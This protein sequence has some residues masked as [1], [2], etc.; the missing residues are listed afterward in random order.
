VD[1]SFTREA[2]LNKLKGLKPNKSPGPDRHHPYVLKELAEELAEPLSI[3]F[4]KSMSEG[5]LPQ[6]WKDASVTPIFKKGK[7]SALGNYRPVS[8]TS[9]VCKVIESLVR[10][11]MVAHMTKNV[12]FS[13]FQHGFISGRSCVTN[14]LAVLDAWTEAMDNGTAVDAVYL[15][16]AKAF[17]TVP[18]ERLLIKLQGY[19]IQDK[20]LGWIQ[21]F[22][23]G[24]RQSV[25]VNGAKS[26][27][28]PVTSGVPQGSVIGPVLFVIFINDLPEVTQSIAQMF[29]DDTKVFRSMVTDDDRELLQEDIDQLAKWGNIWQLRFNADKCKVLHIGRNNPNNQY[30]MPTAD[31]RIELET[32]VLEKD[33]G[34]NVDPELKFS[35]HIERQVNK[36]DKILGMI[37]RSYEFIDRDTMKRL[38]TALVRPLLEFS[39]VAWAP[40]LVK[41]RK[42]IE[43]VQRRA[44]KLVPD[45]KELSYEDRLEQLSLPSLSYQRFR[46]GHDCSLQE[47]T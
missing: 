26:G 23:Q 22:L 43:G 36:A 35:E 17:D 4:Q 30:T 3:I 9:V 12:L 38:F 15:D 42:L 29:A 8:L 7:K 10:D 13:G 18:H 27:W 33:L 32:T 45:L 37:R 31:G 40:R 1:I 46:G 25:I 5:T 6:S 44:T 21:N 47:H 16:F 20:V 19:G 28:T 39:N 24:R 11:H 34:V 2:V 14:L 41:D